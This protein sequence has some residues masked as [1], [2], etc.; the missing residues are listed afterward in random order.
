M[1]RALSARSMTAATSGAAPSA[2]TSPIR[3]RIRPYARSLRP[4]ASASSSRRAV[5]LGGQAP[6]TGRRPLPPA[7]RDGGE[8]AGQGRGPRD[9]RTRCPARA[10]GPGRPGPPAGSTRRGTPGR[11]RAARSGGR[12]C[13]CPS[14]RPRSPPSPRLDPAMNSACALLAHPLRQPGVVGPA[15]QPGGVELG[16]RTPRRPCGCRRRRCR[17][18]RG[19]SAAAITARCWSRLLQAALD[20]ESRGSPGRC[21]RPRPP[22]RWSRSRSTMSARTGGAAVA[23]MAMIRMPLDPASSSPSRR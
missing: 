10:A 11:G 23:V 21:R 16:R 15:D 9:G 17:V 5:G 8:E 1:A 14:R 18:R 3:L 12:P 13:R 4:L 22:G 6:S 2:T 20:T 7:A 19:A